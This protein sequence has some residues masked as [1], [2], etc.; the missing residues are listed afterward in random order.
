MGATRRR[1]VVHGNV[2]GVF[3]RDSTRQE[4]ESR[5]VAGWVRNRDDGAV[6]AVFEGDRDAVQALVDFAQSGPSHADVERIE[7]EDEDPE[8]LSAFEVR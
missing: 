7:V 6:E 3:F 8:G 5:G 2:Q 1:V 4:A